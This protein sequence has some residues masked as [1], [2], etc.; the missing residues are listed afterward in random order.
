MKRN[1]ITLI[2]MIAFAQFGMAQVTSTGFYADGGIAFPL[3]DLGKGIVS[4]NN[5]GMASTGYHIEVGY[6]HLF[7][8]LFGVKLA[9]FYYGSRYSRHKFYNFYS[10]M[11][12]DATRSVE[13]T[14][15]WSMTGLLLKP[16]IF[17]PVGDKFH[18]EV[19]GTAGFLAF[20]T[21]K[22]Q[23]I[24][25]SFIPHSNSTPSYY[26]RNQGKGNS[27]AYGAGSRLVFSFKKMDWFV[28]ADLF[29]SK[30]KYTASGINGSN[31]SYSFLN[32]MNIG[33]F[34]VNIG[35]I[36]YL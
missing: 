35:Y 36:V 33:Y 29:Y 5:S 13:S 32:N 15:G 23:I 8:E 11:L 9:T 31:N 2:L 20:Y 7:T 27:F 34:S 6:N 22:Y 17:L 12:G 21:P 25:Q 10:G 19:N 3:K 18:L 26:Y 4:E 14:Q 24:T 16:F 1:L 28:S 30:I